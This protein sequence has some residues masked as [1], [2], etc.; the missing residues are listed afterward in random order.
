M[1]ALANVSRAKVIV[2]PGKSQFVALPV[3]IQG[4]SILEV[5]RALQKVE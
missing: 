1:I 3:V 2:F 4:V 5:A